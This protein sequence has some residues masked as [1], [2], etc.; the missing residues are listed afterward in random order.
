MLI[1]NDVSGERAA[2]TLMGALQL[3]TDSQ[4]CDTDKKKKNT[5]IVMLMSQHTNHILFI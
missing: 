1:C 3:N 2:F 4:S 5:F